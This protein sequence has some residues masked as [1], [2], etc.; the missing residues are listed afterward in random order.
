MAVSVLLVA[1]V[2]LLMRKFFFAYLAFF[3]ALGLTMKDL[4]E[5]KAKEK[6]WAAYWLVFSVFQ[7]LPSILDGHM[8]YSIIKC[9]IL[10]YFAAFDE[11]TVVVEALTKANE[12]LMKGWEWYLDFCRGNVKM[13]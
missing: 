8:Y 5:E 9:A 4:S 11:C 6:K 12:Y 1:L 3:V 2:Y 10:I 13:D 7:M